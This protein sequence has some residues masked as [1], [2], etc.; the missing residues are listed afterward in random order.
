MGV[1]LDQYRGRIGQW[2]F[3]GPKKKK[4]S[5]P[6]PTMGVL[7]LKGME[8]MKTVMDDIMH[9]PHV[10]KPSRKLSVFLLIF[11]FILTAAGITLIIC[12]I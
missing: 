8:L 6:E 9:G 4:R 5:H 12:N 2:D 3:K 1:T 10:M 7:S 11:L